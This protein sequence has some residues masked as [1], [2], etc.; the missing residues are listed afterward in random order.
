M[1]AKEVNG[2]GGGNDKR[3]EVGFAGN[4][5]KVAGLHGAAAGERE[6][7]LVKGVGRP[8]ANGRFL[9]LGAVVEENGRFGKSGLPY[10]LNLLI[11]RP[12]G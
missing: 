3:F 6:G 1:G 2:C 8:A 5:A 10:E 9:D 12:N 7:G 4:P 11:L